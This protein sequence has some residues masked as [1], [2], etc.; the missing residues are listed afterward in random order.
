MTSRSRLANEAWEAFFRT[1]ATL[2]REFADADIWGGLQPT[3]YAVMHALTRSEDGLRITQLRDDVLITQAGMSRL[4]QRLENRALVERVSD[5]SD[6][7]AQRIRLTAWG[8]ALQRQVGARVASRITV[9]MTRAL[10]DA[11][12]ALLRD[13]SLLLLEQAPGRAAELQ[14]QIVTKEMP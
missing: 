10:D 7:R 2:A 11:Q 1:Q 3:E 13:L 12:L 9:A 14:R 5:I 8:A 6:G 4:I